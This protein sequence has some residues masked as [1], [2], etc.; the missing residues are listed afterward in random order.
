MNHRLRRV[1]ALTLAIFLCASALLSADNMSGLMPLKVDSVPGPTVTPTHTA[2]VS[3]D[4]SHPRTWGAEDARGL[5]G[6]GA[7]VYIPSFVHVTASGALNDENS[8]FFMIRV[9]GKLTLSAPA[10]VATVMHVDTLFTNQMPSGEGKLT[11]DARSH[12]GTVDL[13]LT[14]FDIRASRDGVGWPIDAR[15][16]YTDGLPV[17]GWNGTPVED[18]GPGVLGRYEWD[19]EQLSLGIVAH[20]EVDFQGAP[21][22]AH[23]TATAVIEGTIDGISGIVGYEMSTRDTAHWAVGQT[24]LVTSTLFTQTPFGDP[25]RNAVSHDTTVEIAAIVPL[26]GDAVAVYLDRALDLGTYHAQSYSDGI[27]HFPVI[28][29]LDRSIRVYSSVAVHPDGGFY[30]PDSIDNPTLEDT[31]SVNG[32]LSGGNGHPI[33]Q[34]G[35]FMAMHTDDVDIRFAAFGGM[36]RTDKSALMDDFQPAPLDAE[37]RR[38]A[39]SNQNVGLLKSRRA[40]V[41][42]LFEDANGNGVFD[43]T[44]VDPLMRRAAETI[45]NQR[46]RYS[47]HIHRAGVAP[48]DDSQTALDSAWIEGAVVWNA[49]SWAFVHH[50]SEA[51]LTNNISYDTIGVGFMAE[52][53][54]ENGVWHRNLSSTNTGS[55]NG[56]L[57]PPVAHAMNDVGRRGAAFWMEGRNLAL[58]DNVATGSNVAF[59]WQPWGVD[60]IDTTVDGLSRVNA[61]LAHPDLHAIVTEAEVEIDPMVDQLASISL[62]GVV[63]KNTVIP[64]RY[65]QGNRSIANEFGI[66]IITALGWADRKFNDA[67]SVFRDFTAVE[68]PTGVQLTYTGK[69]LFEDFRVYGTKLPNPPGTAFGFMASTSE[70]TIKDTW[71]EGDN[72]R[73]RIDS[74]SATG[75]PQVNLSGMKSLIGERELTVVER[76]WEAL[77]E[78]FDNPGLA[79]HP[80]IADH[81]TTA[82]YSPYHNFYNINILQEPATVRDE[83]PIRYRHTAGSRVDFVDDQIDLASIIEEDL[84]ALLPHRISTSE[85]TDLA[86]PITITLVDDSAAF[87]VVGLWRENQ[88]LAGHG[89]AQP[90]VFLNQFIVRILYLDTGSDVKQIRV[91]SRNSPS[92]IRDTSRAYRQDVW[93]GALLEFDKTDPLGRQRFAYSEGEHFLYG[94]HNERLVFSAKM[95]NKT[96][97]E[98]GYFTL[99]DVT[100]I[101]QHGESEAMKF[102]Q[103]SKLFTDRL[104]GDMHEKLFVVALDEAWGSDGSVDWPSVPTY[105]FDPIADVVGHHVI[106][107]QYGHYRNGIYQGQTAAFPQ[108]TIVQ[109]TDG[110][111]FIDFDYVDA[112]GDQ[113][114]HGREVVLAGLGNNDEIVGSLGADVLDGGE[115]DNDRVSYYD[116]NEAIA[117]NTK[118][119]IH[120]GGYAEG[121]VLR[122]VEVFRL[123]AFD[124]IFIGSDRDE[125]VW[126]ADGYDRVGTGA[127]D[128]SVR[129]IESSGVFSDYLDLGDGTDG[130]A[131]KGSIPYTITLTHDRSA[132]VNIV[133]AEV[134]HGHHAD[135]VIDVIDTTSSGEGAQRHL[136]GIYGNGGNDELRVTLKRVDLAGQRGNDTFHVNHAS[137]DGF[138]GAMDI[139]ILDF[140]VRDAGDT[141]D[142]TLMWR[143]QVIDLANP[144][145]GVSVACDA[146]GL[147][148]LITLGGDGTLRLQNG[149]FVPTAER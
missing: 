59:V 74:R 93:S 6:H 51:V 105:D 47:V 7:I 148:T 88:R 112:D 28:G 75:S 140:N 26:G 81:M 25:T 101:N 96:L 134:I 57:N 41:K 67:W 122:N 46:G 132:P 99:E 82:T 3:G 128:D 97:T 121:D 39:S 89:A 56:E 69:Y 68:T 100:F 127:G 98:E 29:N 21:I 73:Y 90:F 38:F 91:F 135:D 108:V 12:A 63:A 55:L 109:G 141:Q 4:W 40:Q 129:I 64:I 13:A 137:Y 27:A 146:K 52:T 33:T 115:G 147:T 86:E 136:Q 144:G 104:T 58:F 113:I 120:K 76:E 102:V 87:G 80:L 116:S 24:A 77:F 2:L 65:F 45:V 126:P 32:N 130:V 114:S 84:K 62:D 35:H 107:D 23:G 53:G 133:D 94:T 124:D 111:D 8:P 61:I 92:R 149:C 103:M 36:G 117:L 5:P 31:L 72:F 60:N 78:G 15:D 34:R 83:S 85:L 22:A 54:N 48:R 119:G 123:S 19:P 79:P 14:P 139:R 71:I 10:G 42:R 50:D 37:G 49:P 43:G 44:D 1:A 16:Y 11:I 110:R 131:M 66:S 95:I 17:T 106:A 70:M 9:D 138:S 125:V 30:R 118:T 142:E 20:G 145:P 18:D 143:S